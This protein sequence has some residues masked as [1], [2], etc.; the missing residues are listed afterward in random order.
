MVLAL[1]DLTRDSFLAP[2]GLLRYSDLFIF[3]LIDI[4]IMSLAIGYIFSNA[5]SKPISTDN[6]DPLKNYKSSTNNW[7]NIKRAALIAGPAIALHE[8]SHKFVAILFGAKAVLYAPYG[9]YFLVIILKLLGF[10]FLFLVGAFVSHTPLPAFQS[11]LVSVAGPMAN[12]L[13]W[14]LSLQAVKRKWFDQ[15]YIGYLV[16]F[17]KLNFFLAIFNMI[18]IPGFAGFNFIVFL[19]KAIF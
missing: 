15:K 16:P 13:L 3:E 7:Q 9:M 19:F 2:L 11:S 4:I 1:L 14:Y 5:F 6:Y 10:P 18:P 8:L 17:A 12:L